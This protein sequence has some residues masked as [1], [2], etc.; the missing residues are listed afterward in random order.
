LQIVGRLA[1][2]IATLLQGKDKPTYTPKKNMGDVVIV[3]NAAHVHFT[4]DKWETK[5]YHWHTGPLGRGVA[6]QRATTLTAAAIGQT[7]N[8]RSSQLLG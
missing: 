5:M 7:L 3:I 4:H 2:E 8:R 1:S 6:L